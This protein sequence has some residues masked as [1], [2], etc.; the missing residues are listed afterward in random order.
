MV[1]FGMSEHGTPDDL[2]SLGERLDKAR[3]EREAAERRDGTAGGR[4]EGSFGFAFRIGVDLV[5][6]LAGGVGIGWLIDGWLGTR[7][8]VMIVFFFLG[9]AAGMLNVYRA[10]MGLGGAVGYRPAGPR[11]EQ[12]AR[13]DAASS[14]ED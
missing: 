11:E 2:K 5:V 14:D 7:P 4:P 10:V 1:S 8:W 9:A 3:R 6:P 13:R 12:Q